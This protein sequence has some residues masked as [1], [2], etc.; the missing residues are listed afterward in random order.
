MRYKKPPPNFLVNEE[1]IETIDYNDDT[2]LDDVLSKKSVTIA[3]NKIKKKCKKM[4]AKKNTLS[5][6]IDEME[7]A[8]TIKYV[9]DTD[10]ADVR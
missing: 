1:D 4:S 10:I 8:D 5:F 9:D 7:Q 3:A 6:N 2:S